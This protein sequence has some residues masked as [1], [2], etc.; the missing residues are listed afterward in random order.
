[1]TWKNYNFS[2]LIIDFLG[3]E[4]WTLAVDKTSVY[5]LKNQGFEIGYY[6]GTFEKKEPY[7]SIRYITPPKQIIRELQG[8]ID[9]GELTQVY[10]D[11][12]GVV[13][14]NKYTL[15]SRYDLEER[16]KKMR[17]RNM[18]AKSEVNIN[19]RMKAN[20]N[21]SKKA[22]ERKAEAE[23]LLREGY[24]KKDIAMKLGLSIRYIRSCLSGL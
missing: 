6:N 22:K 1:M 18:R 14:E 23:K 9:S 5:E 3:M 7:T 12:H 19:G 15:K 20:T 10:A 13:Y 8:M 24:S 16:M 17:E 2:L 4:E 21:R 11:A